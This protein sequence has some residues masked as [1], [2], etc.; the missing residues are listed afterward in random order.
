MTAS[1][2]TIEAVHE[3]IVE[4]V[5]D[6]KVRTEMLARLTEVKGNSSFETT[7]RLLW[8]LHLRMSE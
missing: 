6:P 2:K 4:F 7:A 5:P 1:K 3:I 8:E